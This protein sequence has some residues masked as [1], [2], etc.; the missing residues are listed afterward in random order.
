MVSERFLFKRLSENL[1]RW[2]VPYKKALL[3]VI[4][5]LQS[6][7]SSPNWIEKKARDSFEI[8]GVKKESSV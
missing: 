8:R 4:V 7:K 1:D 2:E 5:N 6:S 3:N